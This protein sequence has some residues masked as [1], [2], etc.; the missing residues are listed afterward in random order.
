MTDGD[1]A[2]A[3]ART[4]HQ[5]LAGQAA[6]VAML[7]A[8]AEQPGRSRVARVFG[9]NPLGVEARAWYTAALSEIEVGDELARLPAEWTVLHA[10]PVGVGSSDLDHI[11]I[12]PGGVFIINTKNHPGQVIWVSQRAFLVS[13]IRYP[14]IRNMEYEMGRTERLLSAAAGTPVEVSGVL[15]VVASKSLTVR[16]KHRDVTVLPAE[17]LVDWLCA[18]PRVLGENEVAAIDA[19]AA[20]ESTWHVGGARIDDRGALRARFDAVRGEVRRAWRRQLLWASVATIAG[21]GGFIL[22][23]FS[24]LFSAIASFVD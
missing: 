19:A 11:A 17:Q 13:G 6:V 22:V 23:T 12:G 10:L 15:A 8:Q 2:P 24:I 1:D 9:V 20:L 16:D 5:N 4:L 3:P 7:Q 21:A 14:Y 18:Q